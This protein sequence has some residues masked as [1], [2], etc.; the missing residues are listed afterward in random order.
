[1]LNKEFP[2][3]APGLIPD[4]N[5]DVFLF[6]PFRLDAGERVLLRD[7]APVALTPKAF[8]TL[9]VLLAFGGRLVE[10]D[11]L[12]EEVWHDTYVEEKT[13]AQNVLTIRK[14]LGKTPEGADYIETVPKHGYRFA[15]DVKIASREPL[16]FVAASRSHTEVVVEQE[17]ET[18]D[19]AATPAPHT[20][21]APLA[22]AAA[23]PQ[24][25][26]AEPSNAAKR[27]SLTLA[28]VA[29][30]VVCLL[31][32]VA[33]FALRGG[34][35]RALPFEQFDV[36]KLTSSGD[37]GVM[38]ISPDGKYAA[39]TTFA[40]GRARL[41]V[42]HVGSTGSV[43]IVPPTEVRYSGLTFSNDGSSLF[44]VTR[45]TGS[46]YGTLYQVPVLGGTPKKLNGDVDSP[47]ALSPDGRRLAFVRI[48]RD[49]KDSSLIL[50]DVADGREQEL[51]KIPMVEGFGL[52][53]PTW[54]PDGREIACGSDPNPLTKWSARLLIVNTADGSVRPFS[55]NRWSWIGRAQ[56]LADGIVI[57]AWDKES[58]VMS[59]QVWHLSYPGGEARRITNDVVG[60]AGV[61][62]SRDGS[63]MLTAR[64]ERVASFWSAP[65][66]GG[67][68]RKLSG[69][70]SDLYSDR[71]GVAW[72]PGWKVVYASAGTGN[73]DIWVM[74]DDGSNRRQLTSEPGGNIQPAVSP[75]GRYIIFVS[76]R[77]GQRHI[78]RINSD[79]TDPRQL[80]FG[81]GDVAP[82]VTPDGKWIV[83]SSYV[84]GQP[85]LW[86][87]SVEGGAATQLAKTPYMDAPSVS[88]DGKLIAC[89]HFNDP[90][91]LPK[92]AHVSFADGTLVKEIDLPARY[93]DSVLRWTPDGRGVVFAALTGGVTNFWLVPLDGTPAKQ[94]THF[95]ADRVFRFDLS[96]D[97]RLIYERGTTVS[98][99]ILLRGK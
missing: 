23:R 87:V 96:R 63:S 48:S 44:Y 32:A 33:Y 53:G 8:D 34:K 55:T 4:R 7:D 94:L 80:T 60:F 40:A 73:P 66:A 76:Y 71:W 83:Y 10:K 75:D 2:K 86:K 92:L 52:A 59:D 29:A 72:T 81:E 51:A 27:R 12:L 42:Q 37:V 58:P 95:K 24:V 98:D 93:S 89:Y 38:G 11:R 45:Q 9:L 39:Y 17:F 78:W 6:G 22:K 16:H 36:V 84:E 18:D 65:L 50:L 69:S 61:S 43:E 57:V 91:G 25:A 56:W 28:A 30:L 54:S 19:E 99:A 85:T 15:A 31:L 74:D 97:G 47:V 70:F 20:S 13:L 62:V 68:E 90:L 14:A 64:A 26:S 82:S 41:L 3:P 35:T 1:M 67:E 88:P 77:T 46:N 49:Q 79:G 5:K 21:V